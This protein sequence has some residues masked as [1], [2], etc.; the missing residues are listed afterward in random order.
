MAAVVY[1]ST[2]LRQWVRKQ[3]LSQFHRMAAK[4]RVPDSQPG[5]HASLATNGRFEE[6]T[7]QHQVCFERRLWAGRFAEAQKKG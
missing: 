2:E 3:S 4:S 5:N 1:E 7:P 6:A